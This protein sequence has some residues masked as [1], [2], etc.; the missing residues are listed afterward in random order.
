MQITMTE[1]NTVQTNSSQLKW[2]PK[3]KEKKEQFQLLEEETKIKFTENI[4][5]NSFL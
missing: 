1:T 5:Y 2:L 3:N 4:T